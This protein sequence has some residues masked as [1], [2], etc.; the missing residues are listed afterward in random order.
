MHMERPR[1]GHGVVRGVVVGLVG[2]VQ[3]HCRRSDCH[4]SRSSDGKV[5]SRCH[6]GGPGRNGIGKLDLPVNVAVGGGRVL[7]AG[8]SE[9]WCS[10]R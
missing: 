4:I 8:I 7:D 6:D 2:K 3:R 1:M 9:V 5:Q 10:V